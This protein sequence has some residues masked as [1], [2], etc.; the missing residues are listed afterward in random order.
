MG[1]LA[2]TFTEIVDSL[3]DDWTHL[4]LDLRLEDEKRYIDAALY[5]VMVNAQNYSRHP[6]GFHWRIICAHRF[7]HAAAAPTVHGCLK[8][9]DDA[10]IVAELRVVG[11]REGR[12]P[13][14]HGWGRPESFRRD[15]RRVRA[16]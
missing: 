3:P 9:M 14:V 1:A 13:V 6:E 15:W 2:D 12:A 8:L 7:G 11:V 16:Q 4:D 5:L 10:G